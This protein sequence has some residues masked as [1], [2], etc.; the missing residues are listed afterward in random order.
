[1]TTCPSGNHS[2]NYLK[3]VDQHLSLAVDLHDEITD[4]LLDLVRDR[5]SIFVDLLEPVVNDVTEQ[6]NNN[7]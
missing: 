7:F 3:L 2:R 5:L 6:K 4:G 1:M